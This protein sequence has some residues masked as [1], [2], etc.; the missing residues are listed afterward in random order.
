MNIVLAGMPGSGKTTVSGILSGML[1][2]NLVDTD[3]EIVKKYGAITEI[4]EKYGEECFR[5]LESEI[6]K[7]V[8]KLKDTVVSTG[9]GCLMREENAKAFKACGKI[10]YLRA[11]AQTLIG[12]VG[13]GEGRPLLSGGVEEKILSLMEKRAHVYENCADI[14]VDT[15]GISPE[16][17]AEIIAKRVK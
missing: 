9:G 5:N 12:R 7:E 4:F 16:Q 14:V 13:G 6:V 10:V 11:T 17:V 2:Y 8:C 1:G 15:D 3:G